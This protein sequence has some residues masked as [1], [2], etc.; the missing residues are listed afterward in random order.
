MSAMNEWEPTT[1]PCDECRAW[2]RAR[3]VADPFVPAT[4][5]VMRLLELHAEAGAQLH[6][7]PAQAIAEK[8][9]NAASVV[10]ALLL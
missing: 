8:F 9:L 6:P 5:H 7:G 3:F 10:K 1:P 4:Y 2:V